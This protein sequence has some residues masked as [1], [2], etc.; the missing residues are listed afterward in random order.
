MIAEALS[1]GK[2]LII[3]DIDAFSY[4]KGLKFIFIIDFND[5]NA[6]LKCI[7]EIFSMDANEYE[8]R[9][10]EAIKYFEDNHSV[11]YLSKKLT[12]IL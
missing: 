5:D 12:S 11:N 10:W 7:N 9:Y 8:M 1:H 2:L 6:I 4:L 3:N